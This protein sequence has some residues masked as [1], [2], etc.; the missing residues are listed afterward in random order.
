[1]VGLL[2]SIAKIFIQ[3]LNRLSRNSRS[4]LYI[5]LLY[6]DMTWEKITVLIKTHVIIILLNLH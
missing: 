2:I 3:Q 4:S 1:M 6:N 5:S